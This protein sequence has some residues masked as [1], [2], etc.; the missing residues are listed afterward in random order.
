MM[1]KAGKNAFIPSWISSSEVIENLFARFSTNVEVFVIPYQKYLENML[2]FFSYKIIQ[3]CTKVK[4]KI[5][6]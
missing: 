6:L 2:N 3:Q 1:S 5:S 4:S